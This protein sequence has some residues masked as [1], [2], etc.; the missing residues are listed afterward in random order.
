MSAADTGA[1]A[2][3]A[4][5]D[6]SPYNVGYTGIGPS[7]NP[8]DYTPIISFDGATEVA[9]AA[10]GGTPFVPGNAGITGDPTGINSLH[11]DPA[12]NPT[13]NGGWQTVAQSLATAA[14][15]GFST[16]VSGSPSVG[17][18]TARTATGKTTGGVLTTSTGK[19][20]WAMIALV[21]GGA[22]F[23]IWAVV[24]LV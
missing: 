11:T 9:A 23:G 19:T 21:V 16:F 7:P 3:L 4:S 17:I 1:A 6:Y 5:P 8:S 22:V 10:S 2:F 12:V 13:P 14:A 24:K 15:K 20:N 18:P